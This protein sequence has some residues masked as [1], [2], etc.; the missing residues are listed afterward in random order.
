M[1]YQLVNIHTGQIYDQ[2][3]DKDYLQHVASDL[4]VFSIDEPYQIVENDD[5]PSVAEE[6]K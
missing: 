6:E 1:K 5:T 2:S 4:N 3:D